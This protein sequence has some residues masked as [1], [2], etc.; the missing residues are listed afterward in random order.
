M[1]RLLVIF[2]LAMALTSL[3]AIA[4]TG[5]P[6]V[7]PTEL[8]GTVTIGGS[9][10][11]VEVTQNLAA[12]FGIDG[13]LG[14]V[15]VEQTDT[16]TAF[17]RLCA[18]QFDIALADRQ[19]TPDEVN[20]C[21]GN[22]LSPVG[23]RVASDAIFVAVSPQNAFIQAADSSQLQA[24]FGS[25]FNWV[26]LD[27]SWPNSPIERYGPA[28]DSSA[29]QFFA[30]TIFGG[31]TRT[32]TIA[33]GARYGGSGDER[34]AA[35]ASGALAAGFFTAPEFN[36]NSGRLRA[37]QINGVAPS[38]ET[39]L[40]GS[41]D[42]A[43]PLFLYSAPSVM[44]ERDQVAGFINYYITNVDSQVANVG[45]FSAGSTSL[46]A[47]ANAWASAV[48]ATL[49]AQPV[50]PTSQP[51]AT[52]EVQLAPVV[53]PEETP[54][55]AEPESLFDPETV[56]LITSARNDLELA[57]GEVLGAQRPPGWSGN[58]DVNNPDLLILT[59]LD[60]EILAAVVYGETRR[61]EMWF[62]AVPSRQLS[63]AR[64]IR[65]DLEILATDVFGGEF[66]RPV[67]WVGGD[68][69][70]RCNRSTQ[71]L[72]D[73][74]D[75][76][77]SFD[78]NSVS[79]TRPNYCEAL[80]VAVTQYTEVNLLSG[81]TPNRNADLGSGGGG[82]GV[83]PGQTE[84]ETNFSVAFTD[85]FASASLGVVPFGEVVNPVARSYTQFSN[86][87]LIEGPDYLVFIDYLDTTLTRE[88][89]ED[90][91]QAG[92]DL[93]IFCNARWCR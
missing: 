77:T 86:M 68:A 88:Q 60:L 73:L 83:L 26:E 14:S 76:T 49:S 80:E 40:N 89:F 46:N 27:A 78:V 3:P 90:L 91:P 58:V 32:L 42:L 51:E 2:G 11:L 31:D 61:P 79:P 43:R 92:D 34:A 66:A 12:L 50:Q 9:E 4:Q 55:P 93:Q 36:A 85:R 21:T 52:Q 8:S 67:N 10:T 71:A 54:E 13:F 81:I 17:S 59:R 29:F 45:L 72:V 37:L 15:T 38:Q 69:V 18:G 53:V 62:G 25:A 87:L 28:T 57:I 30:N 63:I 84:I 56:L 44:Q 64:D 23:F 7:N 74:L 19:I 47:A 20:A 16:A 33:I 75:D 41:Y 5:L 22:G 65:H 48:N 1:R 70:L 82:G 24:I 39:I 6:P 35:V